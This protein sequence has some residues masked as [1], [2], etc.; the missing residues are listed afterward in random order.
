MVDSS[1]SCWMGF[2]YHC[3]QRFR[4][5]VSVCLALPLTLK[6]L[7][8]YSPTTGFL[9][10]PLLAQESKVIWQMAASPSCLLAPCVCPLHALGRTFA[11]SRHNAPMR[12]YVTMSQLRPPLKGDLFRDRFG[13]HGSLNPHQLAPNGTSVGSAVFAQFTMMFTSD[14][15]Q[16][17]DELLVT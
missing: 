16:S 4:P 2:V 8:D 12:R 9:H 1:N 15:F 11:C 10:G 6:C 3:S 13:P 14:D 7:C 5:Q 17:D